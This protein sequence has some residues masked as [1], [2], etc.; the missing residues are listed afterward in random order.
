MTVAG[1]LAATEETI[2]KYKVVQEVGRGGMG[3]VYEALDPA[4]SRRVAVKVVH[5]TDPAQVARFDRE[6]RTVARLSHP[7]IAAIYEVGEDKGRPF[8]AMQFVEGKTLAGWPREDRRGIVR[9][10]RDAAL[11][12]QYAHDQGVIHRDV[13]PSNLMVETH[14]GERRLYVLDFG[15]AKQLD[16]DSSL[17]MTGHVIGTPA[18]M[19]PEQ[20]DGPSAPV[21]AR[22]DVWSL[23][24]TIY[25]LVT[26]RTPFDG[27]NVIEILGKVSTKD[28]A[29]LRTHVP[30]VER[31]LE[32][33]VL[34]CLEKDPARRYPTAKALAEDLTRFLDG[35]PIQAHPPSFLRL[36]RRRLAGRK[37][38]LVAAGLA[39]AVGILVPWILSE[40]GK[41]RQAARGAELLAGIPAVL[42]DAEMYARQGD[43][44]RARDRYGD[45]LYACEQHLEAEPSALGWYFYGRLERGIGNDE[46]ALQALDQANEMDP[47]LGEARIERGLLLLERARVLAG[48]DRAEAARL[49][50][51]AREDLSAMSGQTAYFRAVDGTY[52]RAELA[53]LSNDAAGAKKGYEEVLAAEPLYALAHVGLSRLAF[54]AGDLDLAA[55]HA[56]KAIL[57]HKG[58]A[59]AYWAR[60][61]VALSR[62]EQAGTPALEAKWCEAALADIGEAI[63]LGT[64]SFEAFRVRGE[65]RLAGGD[66]K[67]GLEDLDRALGLA[68]GDPLATDLRGEARYLLG[69]YAS[70]E[71]DHVAALGARPDVARTWARKAR[72]RAARGDLLGAEQDWMEALSRDTEDARTYLERGEARAAAR[73]WKG[74]IEDFDRAI[75][76]RQAD[77][78]GYLGRARAR[79]AKGDPQGALADGEA[80]LKRDAGSIEAYLI[81]ADA[82]RVL[83]EPG[84]VLAEF[85]EVIKVD[86]D[87][88]R[89]LE[90]KAWAVYRLDGNLSAALDAATAAIR[91]DPRRYE[92]RCVRGRILASIGRHA[93]AVEDFAGALAIRA[94]AAEVWHDKARSRLA[95]GE[96]PGAIE[97]WTKAIALAPDHVD[98]HFGRGR[99]RAAEG[100]ARGA[101]EDLTHALEKAWAKWPHRTEAEK[102][103]AELR[104]GPPPK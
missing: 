97:D 21:N 64:A 43:V 10:V 67:G 40:Q 13:K 5:S 59:E 19:P 86:P 69:D 75:L 78:S 47:S 90:G 104:A 9:L 49:C 84:M 2:G 72:A 81:R 37:W 91:S 25:Q 77:P 16:V 17:S 30:G 79:L 83:D 62:R 18:Y 66:A 34:K 101:I 87:N 100:D 70:A 1:P 46:R 38:V 71:A 39:I 76:L 35:D 98:A 48:R 8:I 94:D 68:P 89:A 61:V 60:A 57:A 95:L 85:L 53:R 92:A 20:I 96:G 26:G 23:G 54:D 73:D 93:E 36:L 88:A 32:T 22:N 24:A 52:G 80:V 74:A 3:V 63:R 103:L 42:A 65:L 99:A 51:R 4:L 82:Y 15:L 45:G 7:N 29:P 58:L 50:A 41:G 31:D 44:E 56:D 27:V 6:A 12:L 102:L 33:I 11:A 14:G 28:P 55:V